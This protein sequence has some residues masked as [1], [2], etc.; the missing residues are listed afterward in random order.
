MI[1]LESSGIYVD[2]RLSLKQIN[3]CLRE[4]IQIGTSSKHGWIGHYYIYFP[5]YIFYFCCVGV[6]R[7]P[8]GHAGGRIKCPP[9]VCGEKQRQAAQVR[10]MILYMIY[11]SL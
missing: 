7:E 3:M 5:I 9:N 6:S 2:L 1:R 11:L 4:Q 8:A 10:H